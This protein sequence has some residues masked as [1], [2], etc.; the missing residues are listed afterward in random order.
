MGGLYVY[1]M[2]LAAFVVGLLLVS[3]VGHLLRLLQFFVCLFCFVSALP[4][5][6][7]SIAGRKVSAQGAVPNQCVRPEPP[8]LHARQLNI[9]F[10]SL[11]PSHAARIKTKCAH[12]RRNQT[13]SSCAVV[14]AQLKRRKSPE[15][16]SGWSAESAVPH[17]IDT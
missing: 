10:C 9:V 5:V 8:L 3:K 4:E 16:R 12:F 2:G 7:R 14:A 11:S 1:G 17:C 13:K 6:N 15:F